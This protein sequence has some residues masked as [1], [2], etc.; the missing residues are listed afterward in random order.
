MVILEIL[1]N[2]S[3][4]ELIAMLPPRSV[5][6]ISDA[7]YGGQKDEFEKSRLAKI[8]LSVLG[9]ELIFNSEHRQRL[10]G[11]ISKGRLGTLLNLESTSV[12]TKHY[13][14]LEKWSNS[15][16]TEFGKMLGFSDEELACSE[17]ESF[18]LN[19]IKVVPPSYPL[20]PY[21]KAIVTT[22]LAALE[23]SPV[24]FL[25][26][27]PTGSGKTRT[28]MNIVSMYLR[29]AKSGVVLWLADREELCSQAFR[30]FQRAWS[31]LG[32]EAIT[33][34]GFYSESQESL[35]GVDHGF[36]VAGLQKLIALRNSDSSV[37][38]LAYRDLKRNVSLVVFDEAHKAI[39]PRYREIIEDFLSDGATAPSLIGLSATPGRNDS[40]LESD[41]SNL[42]LARFFSSKK[43]T[44]ST[45]GFSSPIQYLVENGFL[46]ETQFISLN[47][48]Q[49]SVFGYRLKDM[50]EVE[51][52]KELANYSERNKTIVEI[53][54]NEVEQGSKVIIF[55]C[56]VEHSILLSMALNY[57]GVPAA[58]V[59]TKSDSKQSRREKIKKYKDGELKVLTNYGVLV[60]GFDEPSTNVAVI[61]KP[62]NSLVEYLQMAGRAMRG[63]KSGG[64][65]VCR[66]YTV[67][68]DLPHYKSISLA[69][70]HWNHI[71]ETE[72]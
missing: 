13:E 63:P 71:W 37:S 2:F 19:V 64:S 40:T 8:T 21:Q 17:S 44:M 9:V 10:I 12:T 46:A 35:S 20:Y 3:S 57:I 36:L 22:S 53:V 15:H 24:R 29:E 55:A 6:F 31:A 68:D 32:S 18:D 60:A 34:Y 4:E 54:K 42:E 14:I 41:Q 66:I 7:V 11:A 59:D 28:A 33:C 56:T 49:S 1:E 27:L 48:H 61:A 25:I 62:T 30:E 5:A 45:P 23:N 72:G 51:T 70:A 16:L 43:I 69:T 26:H 52:N 67:K 47:Y 50:G 65:K 58:S 39:A 38:R